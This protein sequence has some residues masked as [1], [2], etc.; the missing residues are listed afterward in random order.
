[1]NHTA[2]KKSLK[3]KHQKPQTVD[4]EK[5]AFIDHQITVSQKISPQFKIQPKF[6]EFLGSLSFEL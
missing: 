5:N 1:L 6:S 4:N 2:S 3:S